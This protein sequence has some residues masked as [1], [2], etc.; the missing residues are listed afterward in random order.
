[1]FVGGTIVTHNSALMFMVLH[2]YAELR[3]LIFVVWVDHER[4]E[5]LQRGL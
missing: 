4:S 5:V 3:A 1:M 2:V